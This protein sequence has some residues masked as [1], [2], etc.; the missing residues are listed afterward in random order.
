MLSPAAACFISG[1]MPKTKQAR[2]FNSYLATAATATGEM[3]VRDPSTEATDP[4]VEFPIDGPA[5]NPAVYTLQ[6]SSQFNR[7]DR[8]PSSGSS[9]PAEVSA[10]AAEFPT[11]LLQISGYGL[12]NRE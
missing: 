12:V 6:L 2:C 8:H 1:L 11:L 10:F 5:S 4:D 3:I 7:L 9:D